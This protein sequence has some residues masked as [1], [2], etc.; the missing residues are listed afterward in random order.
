MF[1]YY[2]D[3]NKIFTTIATQHNE[4]EAY[5]NYDNIN[6]NYIDSF[7]VNTEQEQSPRDQT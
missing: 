6:R 2:D 7:P 5:P 3:I 1:L 4:Y